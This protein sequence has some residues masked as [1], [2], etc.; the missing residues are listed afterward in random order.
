[1]AGARGVGM[2]TIWFPNGAAWHRAY[3]WQPDATVSSLHEACRV[4]A[5]WKAG[6]TR[7]LGR[8]DR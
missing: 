5:V 3:D 2:R 7:G 1:M 6:C 4:I 8:R